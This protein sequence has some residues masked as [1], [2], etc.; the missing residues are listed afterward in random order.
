MDERFTPG[1]HSLQVS[2]EDEAGNRS[3]RTI[4]LTR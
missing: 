2:V 3:T 4:E 1:K